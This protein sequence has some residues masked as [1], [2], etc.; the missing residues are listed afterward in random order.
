MLYKLFKVGNMRLNK[1]WFYILP[2][3][4]LLIS[5]CQ[6]SKASAIDQPESAG[7]IPVVSLLV[8]LA[9]Q[10]SRADE[11]N[12][13]LNCHSDRERLIETADPVE[14]IAESE[15]RGVG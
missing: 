3:L 9:S 5:G 12:E 13:C 1:Q 15:S 14:A 2:L 4:A 7:E 6:P 10:N 11:N 8:R